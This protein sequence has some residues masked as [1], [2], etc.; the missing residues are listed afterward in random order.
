MKTEN[1]AS[2]D[3]PPGVTHPLSLGPFPAASVR[4]PG[5]TPGAEEIEDLAGYI[6]KRLAVFSYGR[7]MPCLWVVLLGGTGTGK[8]T[9]FNALCGGHLSETGVERPKTDGPIAYAH[10]DCAMDK[11]FPFPPIEVRK[12]PVEAVP[13]GQA[14]TGQAGRLLV[15]EHAR[16]AWSHLI[17]VDTPDLD[18][19]EKENRE[20][21]EDIALLSHL[22][23][24]VTS[25]EKYADE[26][27]Y[28]FLKRLMREKKPY[29]FILNK[30]D[31]KTSWEEV[32]QTLR[33]DMIPLQK[34]RLCLIPRAA[35]DPFLQIPDSPSFQDLLAR[36]SQDLSKEGSLRLRNA[37]LSHQAEQIQGAAER[38]RALCRAEN[39]AAEG[40]LNRLRGLG[41]ETAREFVGQQ[42]ERFARTSQEHLGGEIRRLF[43][44]YDLLARPRRF[45]QE[46][47]LAPFRF[48]GVLKKGVRESQNG[49]LLKVRQKIDL[50]PVENALAKLNHLVLERLSP[51]DKKAPLF[52]GLRQPELLLTEREIK[53]FIMEEQDRLD[54]WLKKTFDE[55]ARSF[56]VSKKWGIYT[57]SLIWGILILSFEAAVGGGF[58]VIDA[59]LDSALAPLVTRGAVE[60]FAYYE[61]RKIAQELAK[62]YR[63]GLLSVLHRQQE[64]YQACLESFM[65]PEE[66]LKRLERLQQEIYH[67]QKSHE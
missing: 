60:L 35:S 56:P 3:D 42:R 50:V 27:P 12:Y 2:R 45:V 55:L 62:R 66:T 53:G 33:G 64:R 44:R 6:A 15:L 59:A 65:T 5:L 61:I 11:G 19:V 4:Y 21:A 13:G 31:E 29:Y 14:A 58:T 54:S 52:K 46:L 16:A 38:L 48:L 20:F 34:D 40:W 49:D 41:E 24:F 30:A 47:I 63:E 57:T 28:L 22:V 36:F 25:Q 37:A 7:S 26:V 67:S 18:S 43:S 8:S 23:L 1:K 17:L 51:A 32:L 39:D 10:K 9:L